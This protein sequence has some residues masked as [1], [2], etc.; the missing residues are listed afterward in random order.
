M[1]VLLSKDIQNWW[2][3]HRPYIR[4]WEQF[5]KQFIEDFGDQN[6]AIKA[7]QAI[8]SLT[9][10]PNETFQQ[11]FL[12]FTKL[13]SHV[14]PEK[15][16]SSKLYIL[17]SSLKPELRAAC[18]S[19]N[20][21]A[22]LKRLCQEYEGMQVMYEAKENKQKKTDRVATIDVT[23]SSELE[24]MSVDYWNNEV[25]WN[26]M[27]DEDRAFVISEN[28]D[29]RKAAMNQSW[30]K[31]QKRDWLAKQICWNCGKTGQ[32]DK[33]WIPHCV[34][35]GNKNAN[36]SKECLKCAGNDKPSLSSGAQQ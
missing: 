1:E 29:K 28:L 2:Q 6:R 26:I 17:R 31:E 24:N 7:E 27:S 9:Q 10:A 16:E 30:T 4:S 11:L 12:R 18:M 14:K 3:I 36:N 33:K 35:C 19:V 5:R 32:C 13:M 21:I 15:S 25:E 34:R 8:A 20:T 22:D 23:L